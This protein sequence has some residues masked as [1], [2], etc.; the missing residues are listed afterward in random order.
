MAAG[1][2]ERCVNNNMLAPMHIYDT[3]H[4]EATR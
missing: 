4:N 1:T 3:L 2:G